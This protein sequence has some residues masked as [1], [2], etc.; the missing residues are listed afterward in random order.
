MN[1]LIENDITEA[2]DADGKQERRPWSHLNYSFS[3]VG[4]PAEMA[5]AWRAVVGTGGARERR[6][7]EALTVAIL[8]AAL[9][10]A[11][12][13]LPRHLQ[14]DALA[15]A[16]DATLKVLRLL[17]AGSAE[18]G[19]ENGL[20]S[21]T[22][23]SRALDLIDTYRRGR[24]LPSGDCEPTKRDLSVLADL[25]STPDEELELPDER[26]MR[27]QVQQ[28][29]ARLLE[30]MP[31]LHEAYR[32]LLVRRYLD[33]VP[34]GELVAEEVACEEAKLG[35][36][37]DDHEVERVRNRIDRASSRARE[38]FREL[39]AEHGIASPWG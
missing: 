32:E 35:R 2:R 15:V 20:V 26:M 7:Y 29:V 3:L 37:L 4:K 10:R 9:R 8:K 28:A 17:E 23:K 22:A 21:V 1:E 12:D 33:E 5:A 6:A 25:N 13:V 34:V 36:E 30:P 31:G 27:G 18:I 24:P 16:D 19:H 38:A 11:R 14:S 39:C